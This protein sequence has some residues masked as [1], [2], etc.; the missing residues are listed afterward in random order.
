MRESSLF[1]VTEHG[2]VPRRRRRNVLVEDLHR[3][4]LMAT[5]E[6]VRLQILV[7][8]YQAGHGHKYISLNLKPGGELL[9]LGGNDFVRQ[10][11]N[12]R[13]C[14]QRV[15]YVFRVLRVQ[16]LLILRVSLPDALIPC[17]LSVLNDIF[18]F[19]ELRSLP[20]ACLS[21]VH[22]RLPYFVEQGRCVVRQLA[23]VQPRV[24][25]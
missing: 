20:L 23:W 1:I 10:D 3:I 8:P 22:D 9:V 2:P 19:A 7:H 13:A 4:L 18:V 5:G 25:F 11:L 21:R 16:Q 24:L 12:D 14:R 6:P 17:R 15:A